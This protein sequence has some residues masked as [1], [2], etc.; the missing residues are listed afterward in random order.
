[1]N[2]TI[3]LLRHGHGLTMKD[4]RATLS[5]SCKNKYTFFSEVW[6]QLGLLSWNS[7]GNRFSHRFASSFGRT[8]GHK[9]NTK[10]PQI[11]KGTLL[12]S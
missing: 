4:P 8:E 7:K 2:L 11:P 12:P 9:L 6:V 10:Q 3:K 1:M 5:N